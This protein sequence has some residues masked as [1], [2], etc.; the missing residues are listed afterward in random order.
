MLARLRLRPDQFLPQAMQED[1]AAVQ[2][3]GHSLYVS[4]RKLSS[5]S[6]T[7]QKVEPGQCLFRGERARKEWTLALPPLVPPA[8]EGAKHRGAERVVVFFT[9]RDPGDPAAMQEEGATLQR[10]VR[11]P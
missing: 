9:D 4:H 6:Q 3:I 11:P 10:Q 1:V 7:R 2:A 5:R 8:V